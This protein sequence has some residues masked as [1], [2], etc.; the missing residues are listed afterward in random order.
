MDRRDRN[1]DRD[2]TEHTNRERNLFFL[3][4]MSDYKVANDDPDVRGW[5]VVDENNQR[6]GKIDNLLVDKRAEKVRYLDVEI[7]E[8]L[9]KEG[10]DA[11]A[12]GKSSGVHEYENREGEVHMVIPIGLARIDSDNKTVISDK[13]NRHTIESG[14]LHRKGEHITPDH[15]RRVVTA[16]DSVESGRHTSE[17]TSGSMRP[18]EA[19]TAEDKNEWVKYENPESDRPSEYGKSDPSDETE[20]RDYTRS[21]SKETGRFPESNASKRTESDIRNREMRRPESSGDTN[22]SQ[23]ARRKER[24]TDSTSKEPSDKYSSESTR[25]YNDDSWS[26]ETHRNPRHGRNDETT[27]GPVQSNFY[28]HRYFDED[29][30][31]GRK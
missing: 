20:R 5:N 3:D 21:E 18:G 31:Y 7:D 26:F 13:I 9:I 22:L 30:F 1:S 23:E 25:P 12:H 8:N 11:Y 4:E 14:H 27:R 29:R 16:L 28:T 2:R 17:N 6:V 10:H 19:R 24:I 15:E